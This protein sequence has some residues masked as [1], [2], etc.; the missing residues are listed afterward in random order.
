MKTGKRINGSRGRNRV[1]AKA[2]LENL[3]KIPKKQT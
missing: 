1:L 2:K 3:P